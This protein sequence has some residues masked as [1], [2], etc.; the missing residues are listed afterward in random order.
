MSLS[1]LTNIRKANNWKVFARSLVMGEQV[2]PTSI[3]DFATYW[4]A[5]GHHM[6]EQVADDALLSNLL[7]LYLPPYVGSDLVLYRGENIERWQNH[8]LGLAWTTSK[9][10]AE[11]FAGGLNAVRTGGVLLQTKCAAAAVICGPN[12]HSTYLGENQYTVEPSLLKEVI[13]LKRY[14]AN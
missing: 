14:P 10:V 13:V 1:D 5:E 6:R 7:R 9:E 2:L 3:D 12:Q 8:E 11:M 4:I